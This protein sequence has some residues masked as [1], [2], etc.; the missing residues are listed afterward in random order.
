MGARRAETLR[1]DAY[2]QTRK[3][4][5]A[6]A[7]TLALRAC[8]GIRRRPCSAD[9]GHHS[10]LVPRRSAGLVSRRSA[11]LERN[12]PSFSFSGGTRGYM[13]RRGQRWQRS[14]HGGAPVQSTN[15]PFSPSVGPSDPKRL[16]AKRNCAPEVMPVR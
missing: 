2:T 4:G 6:P 10:F 12:G 14:N 3:Y 7:P 16:P 13:T 9:R 11:P 1:G 8:M 5:Y 15:Q